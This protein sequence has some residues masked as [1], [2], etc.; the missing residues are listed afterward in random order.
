M[1]IFRSL[2]GKVWHDP[3]AAEVVKISEGQLY[4]V[5]SG[6]VRGGRECIYN[7]AMATIRR[8]PS[9]EHHFQLV[10]TRVYEDGD[11]ELLEDEEETDE[12]RVFLISEELEFRTSTTADGEPTFVWRDL[13]GDIDELYE[14]VAA[15][16][17]EPTRAFFETCM[18]RAMYER[19]YR[20]SADNLSDAELQEFIWRPPAEK[21]GKGKATRKASASN[22]Q[23]ASVPTSQEAAVATASTTSP[24]G[25]PAKAKAAAK[26]S[27]PELPTLAS[28]PAELHL[29]DKDRGMFVK[30]ADVT[31]RVAHNPAG[32]QYDYWLLASTDEGQVLAHRISSDMNQKMSSRVLSVTWNNVDDRGVGNSWC[33]RFLTE[34]TFNKFQLAFTRALWEAMNQ[35]PWDKAKPD[36]QNYVLS[37]TVEDVEMKDVED[38]DDEEDAVEEEL[39]KSE[40]EEE[41]EY[42]DEDEE[43]P[44]MPKGRNK[45]LTVGYKGD[46]S[47]VVRDD[48]IGVFSHTGQ[49]QVKYYASISN[50]ATPKGKVFSPKHVMLHDQDTKMVLM[51][52]A[53]PHALYN[54]DIERGKV[55][56]EWKVHDDITVDAIAPDNKFAQMTPEQTLIGISHNA[57]FRI[58]PRVS[59]TKMVD[60]QFKQYVSR[61][62]FS[63]VATTEAGKLAVASEK[64]DIRLFDSIG[65]NAKTALPPLGDPIIGVDVTADG[66][67]IVATTKTYLLLI[68]TLIGE[69]RYTGQ[70]GF[71]RSFPANAKPIPRRLQLR[72][73]HVAYMD[74]TVSFTPA[75]FNMG[76]GKEENAIVTSTG[77]YVVAWDFAKVKKGHLDKYEIKK[78]DQFVVQDNFKFG[79][80]KEIIVALQNDVLAI[81]KKSLRR[82]TRAS[83][84]PGG[85]RSRSSIVNTPY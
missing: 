84:A 51:N 77:Q 23:E 14:F 72:A 68:D 3:N 44:A 13:H 11:Q 28:E 12:E 71:D 62:K 1:N 21:R 38:E 33:L 64:G 85:G 42:P 16:T 67:W 76:E 70:L 43:A 52:P 41:D 36:E 6:A 53:E 82:P 34:E 83:L 22:S 30:Q 80:D 47:Y 63:S 79:D 5:R 32:G 24:A 49:G 20:A 19:K 45:Q 66:R 17:N 4:L 37:S 26:S 8:V 18:Y 61:N 55:V 39:D 74:G 60:S 9:V 57:L 15:G 56:E 29:W 46:R 65:K 48:K 31:A 10:I 25:S 69:G 7:D 59:G 50:V 78:Y 27:E 75:R 54:L 81:N 73:E 35:W 40:D 58:D 2:I